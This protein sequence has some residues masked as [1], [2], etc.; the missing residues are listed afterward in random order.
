MSQIVTA[1]VKHSSASN[2]LGNTSR[3]IGKWDREG[4]AASKTCIIKQVTTVVNWSLVFLGN[5]EGPCRNVPSIDLVLGMKKV[6]YLQD[7][8]QSLAGHC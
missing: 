7:L 8:L 2:L 6:G 5:P 1:K 4:K 3:D